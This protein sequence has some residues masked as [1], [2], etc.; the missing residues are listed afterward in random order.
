[1]QAGALKI[2]SIINRNSLSKN[3]EQIRKYVLQNSGVGFRSEG[4]INNELKLEPIRK[5]VQLIV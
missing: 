2:K 3:I 5:S 4:K 1:V